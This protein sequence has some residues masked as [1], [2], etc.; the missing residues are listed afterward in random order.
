[1]SESFQKAANFILK[2]HSCVIDAIDQ[3]TAVTFY[4]LMDGVFIT[5]PNSKVI[6]KVID[7]IFSKVAE[8]FLSEEKN[9]YRFIIKGSLSYG[10]IAHGA[11]IDE[12]VCEKLF[13]KVNYKQALMCGMPMIQAFMS[14]HTAPPF[15]VYIHESARTPTDLQ[16]KYYNWSPQNGVN[17][18]HLK[19]KLLSYFHWCTFYSRY[20]ELDKAK[21]DLYVKLTNE[22]FT[23]RMDKDSDSNPWENSH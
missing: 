14:E 12:K 13:K 10:D 11:N 21:I 2:F 8:I 9:G 16:G 23:N 5:S 4:P 18:K 17:K 1:M 6:R 3:A 7:T 20:L 19:E 15:G 22:F